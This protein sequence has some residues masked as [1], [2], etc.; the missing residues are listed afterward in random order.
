MG[1]TYADWFA[2][3]AVQ[4]FLQNITAPILLRTVRRNAIPNRLKSMGQEA[5]SRFDM[6]LLEQIIAKST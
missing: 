5:S 3:A 6:S 2:A 4:H 1:R